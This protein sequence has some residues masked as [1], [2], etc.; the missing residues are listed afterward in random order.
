MS[1]APVESPSSYRVGRD[2]HAAPRV[3]FL[4]SV[5]RSLSSNDGCKGGATRNSMV[6]ASSFADRRV[7]GST[8]WPLMM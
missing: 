7:L 8:S 5:D 1:V 3:H 4:R 6:W 2:G